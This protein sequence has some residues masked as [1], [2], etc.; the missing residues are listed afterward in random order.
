MARSRKYR[1]DLT[2]SEWHRDRLRQLYERIGHRLD[3]AD[4]DW[5]EFCHHCKIPFAIMEEV[6]D[7][8]QNLNEK[9]TRVTRNLARM[10]GVEAY[11]I[12]PRTERPRDIQ[13][14]I[15]RL[16]DLI[17]ELE[18]KHPI[19]EFHVKELYPEHTS[20]RSLTPEQWA[21]NVLL[22]HR[23]HHETC[24]EARR[25]G[26]F[27]VRRKALREAMDRNGIAQQTPSLFE[28]ESA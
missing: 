25:A 6:V 16:Q 28:R 1:E 11:L 3:M 13:D 4:R 27:P 22:L 5:T 17:T 23:R 14:E 7:R 8:G 2:Y 24:H 12:A 26:E 15:N 19:V 21:E 18:S 9:S 20:L 10:A